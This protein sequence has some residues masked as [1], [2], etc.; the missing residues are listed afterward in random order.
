MQ[1]A[2][3]ITVF[4]LKCLS[5]LLTI[6]LLDLYWHLHY[7]D[8]MNA[9]I[10]HGFCFAFKQRQGF[11]NL[12]IIF[13]NDVCL[14]FWP[15]LLHFIRDFDNDFSVWDVWIGLY[16]NLVVDLIE[17]DHKNLLIDPLVCL[18]VFLERNTGSR[19]IYILIGCLIA[20]LSLIPW[21]VDVFC[22]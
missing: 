14:I 17:R 13:G 20:G 5:D 10:I 7:L 6:I 4:V 21:R 19:R 9:L 15:V 2:Y 22:F 18:R 3:S 16:F 11:E 1:V 12:L 8:R